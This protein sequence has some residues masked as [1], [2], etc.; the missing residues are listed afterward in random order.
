M[1]PTPS[2]TSKRNRV[3]PTRSWAITSASLPVNW[4]ATITSKNS[5][6]GGPKNYGYKT[7]KGH[8][9]CKVRGFRLNSE[10]KTQLNY[11]VMRQKMLDEIQKP[12]KEP[13]QT[14]VIKS[15]QICQRPQKVPSSS[16]ILTTSVTSWCRTRESLILPHFRPILTDTEAACQDT[17]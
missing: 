16:P 14:Q 3:N 13:R 1:T 9:E 2:F 15:N 5:C 4:T 11:D 12:Q 7:K 8:V 17:P 10:G 6:P